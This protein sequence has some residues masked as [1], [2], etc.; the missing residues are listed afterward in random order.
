LKQLFVP[1][2]ILSDGIQKICVR[3]FKLKKLFL[4]EAAL[5][6]ELDKR[7]LRSTK[8]KTIG[9]DDLFFHSS[10]KSSVK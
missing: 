10:A 1:W 5:Y 7:L 4:L 9:V 6:D 3:K 2:Q 8:R